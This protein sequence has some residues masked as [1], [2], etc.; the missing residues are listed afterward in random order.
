MLRRKLPEPDGKSD[1]RLLQALLLLTMGK[2]YPERVA[3][4]RVF[5]VRLF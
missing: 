3:R 5:L 1:V 2:V 4:C